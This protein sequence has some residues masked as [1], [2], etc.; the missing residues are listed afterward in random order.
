MIYT[1]LK[2][3]YDSYLLVYDCWEDFHADTF[4]PEITVEWLWDGKSH[5]K[6]YAERKAYI[7]DKAI[8][9]SNTLGFEASY[10]ALSLIGDA[11]EKQGK[12]Y[13]LMAEF[14]ENCI[15]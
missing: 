1:V 5:G 11:F 4:S 6:T 8:E 15:C 10:G 12:R 7:Q 13:G 3:D 14:K 2:N 9:Y